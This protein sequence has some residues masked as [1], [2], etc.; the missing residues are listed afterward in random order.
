MNIVRLV[1]RLTE[2]IDQRRP[3]KTNKQQLETLP[4]RI[5]NNPLP[6]YLLVSHNLDLACLKIIFFFFFFPLTWSCV[7]L[8]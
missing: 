2:L 4:N 3:S 5:A 8:S 7:L 6:T 1:L